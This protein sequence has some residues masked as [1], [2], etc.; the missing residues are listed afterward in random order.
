MLV[1]GFSQ[2]FSGCFDIT[3]IYGLNRDGTE[4]EEGTGGGTDTDS[5]RIHK[6]LKNKIRQL[7]FNDNAYAGSYTGG[8]QGYRSGEAMF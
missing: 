6:I 2:I 4:L 1:A 3:N 5:A 8:A 7:P